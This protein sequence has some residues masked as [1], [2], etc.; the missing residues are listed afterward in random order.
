[1]F[2]KISFMNKLV[3][4]FIFFF[5]KEYLFTQSKEYNK[6]IA[7]KI[8]QQT[9]WC[10]NLASFS[11]QEFE[12]EQP[13]GSCYEKEHNYG[14]WFTFQAEKSNIEITIKT[15]EKY[16]TAQ[17]LYTY[18]FNENLQELVC[19]KY[20][21]KSDFVLLTYSKL[22]PGKWYYIKVA[23][24]NH[25]KYMGTFSLCLNNTF[26][27]DTWQGAMEIK[28]TNKWCTSD[29][30]ISTVNA[31]PSNSK[32]SCLEKGPNFN[33]WFKFK[34][35]YPTIHITVQGT[36]YEGTFDF[37]YMALF[38]DKQ[39][40]LACSKYIASEK[41]NMATLSYKNLIPNQWYYFSVDHQFN[42]N[43][44]GSFRV[45]LDDE[46]P[47][48]VYNIYGK[49]SP[50][51]QPQKEIKLILSDMQNT[52][53]TQT[54]ADRKGNF[55]FLY[56]PKD[57]YYVSCSNPEISLTGYLLDKQKNILKKLIPSSN[58]MQF[59][60]SDLSEK[61][62]Y[63]SLLDC[64]PKEPKPDKGKVGI[65]GKVV[66]KENPALPITGL[67]VEI[68]NSGKQNIGKVTTTNDGDFQFNQLEGNKE[69]FLRFDQN[70]NEEIYA[71]M[72]QINDAG[73]PI[74]SSS[75]S[76]GLD[77]NG[78]FHFEPLPVAKEFISQLS[79]EDVKLT[80]FNL[81]N[82]K[83]S[84]VLNHLHFAAGSNKLL[85]DSYSELNNLAKTLELYP[86]IRIEI[87]GH[88][89]NIGNDE[90][91]IQLSTSRA[92]AVA[93]YL[94]QKG[95]PKNRVEYIGLGKSKPLSPNDT[96]EGRTK[97]RRV[98]IRVID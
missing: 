55:S 11:I 5:C 27:Y 31:L 2:D 78:F 73:I 18:L 20:N 37:P 98:E 45:C 96:E 8:D 97:N 49:V 47:K 68:Y 80:D 77:E 44:T 21:E 17:L 62:N 10:S 92:K 64:K 22:T 48:E 35:K 61:C 58:K 42:E 54:V 1:M 76:A 12:I 88:T 65:L 46:S 52:F 87:S 4:V 91:N 25:S 13:I 90:I 66:L 33:R 84:L 40:E 7:H 29:E 93:E 6:T 67:T 24:P 74:L 89:D 59:V 9:S 56:I 81:L 60:L 43:Y 28:N 53:I 41:T 36:D 39:N 57:A 32:A 72:L 26:S 30:K 85:K 14:S 23:T 94:F 51:N 95:I 83:K 34:A 19:V 15:G 79:L 16:G 38:D 50:I 82:T 70:T 63:L 69:Y 3:F 75:T 86:D 71:E